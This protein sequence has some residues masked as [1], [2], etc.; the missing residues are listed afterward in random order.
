MSSLSTQCRF[1]CGVLA[2]CTSLV[3]STRSD[4]A[5]VLI[6]STHPDVASGVLVIDGAGF[7]A[8]LSVGLESVDLRVLS[9]TAHEVKATLP[10]L[11]SGSYGLTVRQRSGSTAT[12]VVTIG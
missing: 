11:K 2:L 3:S 12:F 7:R 8:G 4:A 9:V 1:V 6:T 5:D 10:P